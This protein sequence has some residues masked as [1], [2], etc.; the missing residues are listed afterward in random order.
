MSLPLFDGPTAQRWGWALIHFIWQ[1]AALALLLRLALNGLRRRSPQWRYVAGCSCLALMVAAPVF[2]FIASPLVVPSIGDLR[3]SRALVTG[4]PSFGRGATQKS[5]LYRFYTG[6]RSSAGGLIDR[7]NAAVP[8]VVLAWVCGVAMLSVRL[9][10]NWWQ[11]RR[12]VARSV[13]LEGGWS[14]RFSSLCRRLGVTR[15]VRLLQTAAGETPMTVGW[16]RPV[17]LLPVSCLAG[18]PLAHLEA[19]VAHELAHIRRHDY[20]VNLLQSVAETLLFYHPAVWWVS[21][22]IRRE[23]EHCCDD[24]AVA[25]SGGPLD[26][27]R[28]LAEL[29]TVRTLPRALAVAANDGP[30]LE[31]IRR[32]AGRPGP[33]RSGEGWILAGLLGTI[34]VVSL[35]KVMGQPA[36]P[37]IP[38]T[39]PV[40]PLPAPTTGPSG[41]RSSK[42]QVLV[43]VKMVEFR[44]AEAEASGLAPWMQSFRESAPVLVTNRSGILQGPIAL[45]NGLTLFEHPSMRGVESVVHGGSGILTETQFTNL[46][47]SLEKPGVDLLAA[48]RIVTLSGRQ[49]RVE[50]VDVRNIVTGLVV[51][52]ETN[53]YSTSAVPLG[54]SIDVLPSITEAGDRVQIRVVPGLTGLLGYDDPGPFQIQGEDGKPVR[55]QAPLPRFYASQTAVDV[56]VPDGQTAMISGFPAPPTSKA[57]KPARQV[58]IFVTPTLIDAAGN[59][60]HG[61]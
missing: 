60:I 43:E 3:Q 20:L 31:R 28:A 9:G 61:E 34:L 32:L 10:V 13:P 59:R 36:T 30:L 14:E 1:A 11:V 23:R 26:Y 18:V 33:G 35:F 48:P 50:I 7:F 57:E 27:A 29:E 12:L 22:Q 54:P 38:A 55:A 47:R 56:L 49:A 25:V 17:V 24:L 58:V 44:Q 15:A 6:Q 39:A 52:G 8:A 53:N 40:V 16:L 51:V 21:A 45:T 37:A 5:D 2:T 42:P 4:V 41:I 46:L 19:L